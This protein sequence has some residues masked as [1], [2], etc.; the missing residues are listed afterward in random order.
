MRLHRIRPL[1]LLAA[2][3]LA[4]MVLPNAIRLVTDWYWF[5][6]LGFERIFLTHVGAQLLVGVAVGLLAFGFLYVN[7]GIAYGRARGR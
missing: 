2:L 4:L 6:E 5:Q 3:F 1:V 7:Y